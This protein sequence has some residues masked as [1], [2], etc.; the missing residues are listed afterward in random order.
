MTD[1][2]ELTIDV[3]QAL[4]RAVTEGKPLHIGLWVFLPDKLSENPTVITLLNGGTYDR[5]YFHFIV[6][7]REDYSLAEYL[8]ARGHVVILPDHLGIG[9]SDRAKDQMLVTREIAAAANHAA[10]SEVYRRLAEG[11]LAPGIPAMPDFCKVGGGHSMGA[12]QTITQQAAH[13]TYDLC[14][15]LGYTAFGVHLTIGGASVSAHPGPLDLTS[16]DYAKRDRTFLRS[17]FH[18]D[19]V[20]DDVIA[21]DDSLLVEVPYVL[22][23]QAI[24]EGIVREDAARIDVP[25]Y[26]NLGE[27][28]VSPDPHAEPGFYRAS[29]DI[30]LHILPRSGHCQNFAET[31][32]EMYERIDCWV[33]ERAARA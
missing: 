12:F 8:R 10:V 23:T 1:P 7:G 28:D 20:P 22:S 26:I 19:D 25:V 15:I 30:T 3:S 33:R 16:P 14:L 32:L 13:Q 4:P 18:W 6:P 9:A 5:R 27:R 11:S 31:R 24:T 17:T 29:R 21:V 2:V